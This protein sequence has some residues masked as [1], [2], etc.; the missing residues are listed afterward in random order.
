MEFRNYGVRF[1]KGDVIGCYLDM[2][3]DQAIM[4]FAVN[5]V[6]QGIAYRVP[7]SELAGQALFPHVLTKN[8]DYTI[9]FGQMPGPLCPLEQGYTP[10]GQ[11]D[12]ADGI[13]KG[14][15]PPSSRA[16]CEA[17]MMIGLPGA[18]KTHWAEQYRMAN[19]EKN[20]NVLGTN[21]LIEKMKVDGLSRKRNYTGRCLKLSLLLPASF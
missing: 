12:F 15:A 7:K 6:D 14:P 16:E 21:N 10:I 18:G 19:P 8:Q 4:R 2:N 3:T 11:L 1:G 13:I 20:Y 17:L 9:N 5:G